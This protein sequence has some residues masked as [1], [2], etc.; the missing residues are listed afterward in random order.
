MCTEAARRERAE[1]RASQVG[2]L[3]EDVGRSS[4]VPEPEA[5]LATLAGSQALLEALALRRRK[6]E[7][8][9]QLGT[10]R[11][12]E[13]RIG[14]SGSRQCIIEAESPLDGAAQARREV[15][16]PCGDEHEVATEG[17]HQEPA[18]HA[19]S[20]GDGDLRNVV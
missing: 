20:S 1:K 19:L 4:E 3:G 5:H 13:E 2:A 16:G 18:F 6:D 15:G 8:R 12:R 11:R 7:P 10:Y 9:P 14:V 17:A